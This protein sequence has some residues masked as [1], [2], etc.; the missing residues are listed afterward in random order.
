MADGHA[1]PGGGPEQVIIRAVMKQERV[2][3]QSLF[4]NLRHQQAPAAGE[5]AEGKAV[6]A[7]GQFE[8][9]AFAG[10]SR[11]EIGEEQGAIVMTNAACGAGGERQGGE[12]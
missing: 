5:R 12:G 11:G 7:D 3:H 8:T 4:A 10:L 1:F 6:V 2:A 9:R